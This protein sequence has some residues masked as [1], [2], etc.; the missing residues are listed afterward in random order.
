M[1][2]TGQ[3]TDRVNFAPSIMT[4]LRWKGFNLIP[5]FT[6]HETQYSESVNGGTVDN[7]ISGAGYHRNAR[8]IAVDLVPP[9]LER[10]FN[11]KTWLGDKLKHVI[12][13]RASFRSVTGV[14]DFTRA[15][16]FDE[17]ELLSNTTE[18]EV[19]ITNRV[20]TKTGDYVTEILS[21]QVWQRRYF[22]PNFGGAVVEGRRNVVLSSADLTPYTF[23]DRPRDYSPVVSVLRIVPKPGFGI[24][25]RADYDPLR[26]QIVNSGFTADYRLP[27]YFFSAGHNQVH[28]NPLLSPSGNQ[29]R[30]VIGYGN[31]NR[32]GWNSAFTAIYDYRTSIM[33]FATMQVTYNTDCCGISVQYR[34]FAFGTRNDNQFRVAFAVANVGAFGTLKKQERLF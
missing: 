29:L 18:A 32:R 11:R 2:Q 14:A 10:V 3:F 21:W 30:G 25:W 8:E 4:A 23:L 5:S 20:F 12:E 31:V 34:R 24:E 16:R 33:Q 26:G 27:K 22:D 17:T 1:F 15:I 13:P 9:S 28:S 6:L 19:S 7:T